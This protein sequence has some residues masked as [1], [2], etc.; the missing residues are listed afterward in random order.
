MTK[1]L[2][3]VVTIAVL[4][5]GCGGD[6]L[7]N[8]KQVTLN[9]GEVSSAIIIGKSLQDF[10]FYDQFDKP[11][12]LSTSTKKV[13]F[14]FTKPTGHLIKMFMADKKPNYLTSRDIIFIA[15]ISGMPSIIAKMFAI[16]DMQ[17]SKYPV[18]LIKEKEKALGFRNEKH[19]DA[20][21]IIT[22]DNKIVKD[23]KFVTNAK[24]LEKALN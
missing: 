2:L 8:K 13:M 19:K 7:E 20:A 14:A 11:V 22:L 24:D 18:L 21:M 12:S 6:K 9:S 10:T 3:A 23:V 1:I 5:S 4:F 15:D 17:E 16:P